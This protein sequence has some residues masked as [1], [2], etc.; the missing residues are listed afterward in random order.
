MLSARIKAT[1]SLSSSV[2]LLQLVQS[3]NEQHHFT[4]AKYAKG[5][6][7]LH[8]AA[9][10]NRVDVMR[11]LVADYHMDIAATDNE[12]T[13][14]LLLAKKA[15]AVEAERFCVEMLATGKISRFV[16]RKFYVQKYL[17]KH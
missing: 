11:W 4:T 17:I 5:R 7:L 16:K 12:G 15:G 13:S 10:Y 9:L 3:G 8:I 6:T 2:S 14:E 1:N